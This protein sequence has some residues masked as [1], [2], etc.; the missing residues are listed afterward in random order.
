M[1]IVTLFSE[2]TIHLS[3]LAQIASLKAKKALI[4]VPAK[5]L[6]YADIF[7]EKFATGLPEHT[8]INT[9][10]IELERSN[11]PFYGL[12]YSLEQS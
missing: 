7:F 6:D 9:H 10:T 3:L 4:T 1:H 2:I 12:I 5:Y 8:E 11:Q